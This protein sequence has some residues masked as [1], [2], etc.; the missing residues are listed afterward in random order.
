MPGPEASLARCRFHPCSCCSNP[1]PTAPAAR[2]APP[3]LRLAASLDNVLPHR[4]R[5]KV[6]VVR[7]LATVP[8]G[9]VGLLRLLLALPHNLLHDGLRAAARGRA[10]LITPLQGLVV[11]CDR[12]PGASRPPWTL[13]GVAELTVPAGAGWCPA[14]GLGRAGVPAAQTACHGARSPQGEGCWGLIAGSD[15][16]AKRGSRSRP[17][18]KRRSK[19]AWMGASWRSVHAVPVARDAC[20]GAPLD[21]RGAHLRFATK[22]AACAPSKC[23]PKPYKRGRCSSSG[24]QASAAQGGSG[25]AFVC[26]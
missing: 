24:V 8:H 1:P 7:T 2:H 10:A 22:S 18:R 15:G 3:H 6:G 9:L 4:L 16:R 26:A 14:G 11:A 12:G 17:E 13:H 19:Q 20:C 5:I 21:L 23:H 25:W